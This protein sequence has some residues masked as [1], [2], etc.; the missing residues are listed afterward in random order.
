MS[1]HSPNCRGLKIRKMPMRKSWSIYPAAS[2]GHLPSP[3]FS[4]LTA[5]TLLCRN[6]PRWVPSEIDSFAV[7]LVTELLNHVPA[8]G[9]FVPGEVMSVAS[10]LSFHSHSHPLTSGPIYLTSNV[11][12]SSLASVPPAHP[13]LRLLPA[14]QHTF[15]GSE[16]QCWSVSPSAWHSKLP[17]AAHTSIP[18]THSPP[19]AL[20]K[21]VVVIGQ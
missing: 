4:Q 20:A 13:L 3:L 15:S 14:Q 9:V 19:W 8:S 18:K 12:F 6:S 2:F 17:M 11:F 7:A 16:I 5:A 10:R 21:Q 1:L